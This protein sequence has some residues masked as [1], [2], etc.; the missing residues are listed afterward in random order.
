[1]CVEIID[2]ERQKKKIIEKRN[3]MPWR[4]NRE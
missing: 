4:E 2:E 3:G 1:M